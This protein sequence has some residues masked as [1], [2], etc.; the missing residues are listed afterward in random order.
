MNPASNK[1]FIIAVATASVTP[2]TGAVIA[3]LNSSSDTSSNKSHS[4]WFDASTG[5][6]KT[7]LRLPNWVGLRRSTKQ[8]IPV[9]QS[10]SGP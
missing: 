10:G 1:Q 7:N 2:T 3:A 8:A 9:S 4:S 6:P 5:R